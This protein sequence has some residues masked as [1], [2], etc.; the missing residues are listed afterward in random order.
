MPSPPLIDFEALMLPIAGS[1]AA[2]KAVPFA[3]REQLETAR[4]EVDPRTFDKGDPLRP[5]E[6]VRADWPLVVR[7]CRE[8]LA[9]TSKDML[10]SARLTEGLTKVNG[11]AGVRDGLGLMRRLVEDCWDRLYPPIEE[12]EDAEVRAAAFSWL[13][14]A[15]RGARFPHTLRAVP[16][17]GSG[18]S[19]LTWRMWK[20]SQNAPKDAADKKPAELRA[21]FEKAIKAAPREVCQNIVDDLKTANE[22][23]DALDRVLDKLMGR[24]APALSGI[25][26]GL[27]QCLVLAEQILSQKGPAPVVAS[28]APPPEETADLPTASENGETVAAPA[29]RRAST[30]ADHY[31]QIADTAAAL[32]ELEPH[33]P[34]PYLLERAVE[35]GAMPFPDLMKVLVRNPEVLNMMNRELGIRAEDAADK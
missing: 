15:D 14:D 35:L 17:L 26:E 30:R 2:G 33:S 29:A 20:E 11:F 4:K 22:E 3:I 31:Q 25:R 9:Q 28:A 13:N 1:D 16:L 18:E 27:G 12:E 10:I 6:E 23:L 19:G 34:I 7:L 21:A 32:K 24:S 8:T 5:G